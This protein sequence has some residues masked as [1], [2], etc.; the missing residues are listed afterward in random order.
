M[1]VNG[2]KS[3]GGWCFSLFFLLVICDFSFVEIFYIN[4][5]WYI[6]IEICRYQA[7]VKRI[8]KGDDM[9]KVIHVHLLQQIDGVKRRDWYFS[10]LSAVF[11]VFTPEQVGVT[12]NYLLH[13]GLSGGGVIINKRA[14]IRQSTLIG[15]S[16]GVSG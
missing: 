9:A 2:C 3:E 14:V 15:C 16:R 11:T 5:I 8:N 4:I 1:A 13:A 10:S 12:K 7:K 6:C